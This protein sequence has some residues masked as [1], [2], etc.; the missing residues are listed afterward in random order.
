[1]AS[2]VIGIAGA[3]GSGKSAVA[4]ALVAALGDASAL[5]MDSYERMTR[6]SMD[7]LAAW[8]ARGADVN[9][10]PVPLLAEHLAELKAGR[11]VVDPAT[12]AAILPA[13]YVVFETQFGRDHRAT[14]RHIDLLVWLDTP[15]EIALAR[16]LRQVADDALAAHP[17][18]LRE[19]MEWL[20]GY[21]S[22]YLGL[23]QRLVARQRERVLP[24]AE[25]VVDGAGALDRVVGGLRAEVERRFGGSA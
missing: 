24:G 17:S 23:V 13:R 8:A 18:E 7:E 25:I 1:M 9:E 2:V 20:R 5:H 21:L 16:T 14:G 19:R 15:R 22:N 11:A 12:G 4:R 3:P 6:Q 10:L